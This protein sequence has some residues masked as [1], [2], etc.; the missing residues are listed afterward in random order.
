MTFSNPQVFPASAVVTSAL[1]GNV[2]TENDTLLCS[3]H[4]QQLN[5]MDRQSS[6]SFAE[7]FPRNYRG[8]QFPFLQGANPTLP[9]ASICQPLLD[10]SCASGNG[11]GGQKVFFDGLN[12]VINSDRALSLLSSLPPREIHEIGLSSMVQQSP[13]PPAQSLISASLQYNGLSQYASSQGSGDANGSS[14][15]NNLHCPAIFQLGPDASS[16]N[17]PHH[18]P[19]S[20]E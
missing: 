8:K 3:S 2:K 12:R 6:N 15:A 19:S 14:N 16:T 4:H 17:G 13:I 10:P 1:A 7:M 11:S 5:F 9:G 20:W 18:T